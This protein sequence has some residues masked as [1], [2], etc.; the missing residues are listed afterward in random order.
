MKPNSAIY[1]RGKTNKQTNKQQQK[2]TL[3]QE[4]SANILFL[5]L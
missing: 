3:K 5:L 1:A 4:Y 2:N